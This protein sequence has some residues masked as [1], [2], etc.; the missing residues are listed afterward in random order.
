MHEGALTGVKVLDLTWVVVG[1]TAMRVLADYGATVVKVESGTRVDTARTAGPFMNGTPGAETS[2]CF[3]NGNAGKLGLTL[4]LAL[5]EAREVLT[6][7]VRWADIAAEN[8]TPRVMRKWGLDYETLREINPGLVYL[9]ASMAGQ[10]GPYAGLAAIG[11]VGAA[12]AGFTYLVGWPDRPPTGPGGAYTDYVASKYITAAVL[13]ALE[14]RDRTGKGQ[15]IDLAQFECSVHFLTPTYLDY[16]VNG[17]VA[18]PMGNR[19][20][21][22][23]PHGVFPCQGDD[24]WIAIAVADEPQWVVLAG[25]IGRPDLRDDPDLRTVLG[26]K[27]REDELE[28]AIAAW[29]RQLPGEEIERLLIEHGVPAHAALDSA[30]ALADPQLNNRGHFPRVRHPVMG[31]ITLEASRF[32]LSRT[33]GAVRDSGPTFGRD[34]EYVLTE[35]L[36]MEQAEIAELAWRGVFD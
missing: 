27:R 14:Y 3:N 13:A 29:T 18:A 4:N 1:P 34:T 9:G 20:H 5:P 16:Q 26:R 23:A 19:S 30:G 6:R 7:L 36:G 24:R 22:Y 17:R 8:F 33:P 2:A 15:Y 25:A 12:M 31:E 11:N 21:E 28:A 10:H 32:H 35:L